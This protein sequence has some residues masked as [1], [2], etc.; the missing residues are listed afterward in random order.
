M[1]KLLFENL[2]ENNQLDNTVV[3]LVSDH[4]LYTLEDK[5]LLDKYKETSNNLINHTPFVIWSNGQIKKTIKDV[6]SQLDILPTILNLFGIEYNVNNYI[7]RDIFSKDFD[8]LVFFPDGSWYNGSTYV[9][10]GE[11]Q[12]GKKI[13][14]E[15][16]QKYNN[17]VK[18]K[19]NLND[20]V[21]KSNY[22]E[23]K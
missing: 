7:G 22:F 16:L 12:N 15:K 17:I 23:N 4:Y 8:P 13:S 14:N 2:K 21:L 18:N 20:A 1:I 9:A 19:M 5:T 6:N 11:Y 3:I 10:N